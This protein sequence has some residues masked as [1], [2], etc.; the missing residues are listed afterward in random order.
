LIPQEEVTQITVVSPYFDED[1]TA[2]LNL[3]NHFNK[4]KIDVYLPSKYG[5]PPNKMTDQQSIEFYNWEKTKRG[6][7]SISSA[8]DYYRKLHSK[9]IHF[10]AGEYEYC[11]IGSANATIAGLGSETGKTVNEEFCALYKIVSN[12]LLEELGISGKKQSISVTKLVR[13]QS[14]ILDPD[15]IVQ[16][17]KARI[18]CADL[19][20]RR[21]QINYRL[22]SNFVNYLAICDNHGDRLSRDIL[23]PEDTNSQLLSFSEE[24]LNQNPSYVVFESET[25]DEISNKQL[26]NFIDKLYHTDPSKGNRTIRQVLTSLEGGIINE[27]EIIEFINDLNKSRKAESEKIRLGGKSSSEN[28]NN[29]DI[30]AAEMTYDEAIDAAKDQ[31]SS[32]VIMRGHSSTRLWETISRLFQ[33]K[34]TNVGEELMDEEEEGTAEKSRD[35]KEAN[36]DQEIVVIKNI[37]HFRRMINSVTKLA[38][39]Y[40]GQLNKISYKPDHQISELDLGNFLLVTHVLTVV[41]TFKEYEFA[42]EEDAKSHLKEL[43]QLYTNKMLGILEHFTKLL[44]KKPITKYDQNDYQKQKFDEFFPKAGY[45]FWLYVY[46]IQHR[47]WH[48]AIRDKAE[49]A[50][51]NFLH[52]FG[53]ANNG[54]DQYLKFLSSA[55]NDMYF[56]PNSVV[57]LIDQILLKYIKPDGQYIGIDHSGICRVLS[58]DNDEI[59]YSSLF[60]N[61]RISYG[62]LKKQMINFNTI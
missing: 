37:D 36:Q 27:F 12:G 11:V 57:S 1:G 44:V 29:D 15:R 35:R 26:I 24:V 49:L 50:A 14:L 51:M 6:E 22:A 21:L 25:G 46:L 53:A 18:L 43:E 30:S 9:I 54:F 23:N 61:G 59:Y 45:H 3:K 47:S 52:Y 56:N 40:I 28:E 7:Q 62:K 55:Y 10:K 8:E 17:K 34:Q 32:E 4:A 33:E 41:C 42:K 16:T 39:N 19:N 31:Q 60:A 58:K 2:L 38:D 48:Q 5:L 20:G 13:N